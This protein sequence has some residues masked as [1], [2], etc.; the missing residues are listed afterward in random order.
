MD[1][2]VPCWRWLAVVSLLLTYYL[3]D[4]PRVVV[5]QVPPPLTSTSIEPTLQE[6]EL[7]QDDDD[8]EEEEY[9]SAAP[10]TLFQWSY[11]ASYEGGPD[12]DE[13]LVTDR[14]DFTEASSTVGL[15][16]VQLEV[17]YTYTRDD[18][19]TQSVENHSYGEP[20]LRIGMLANWFELRVGWN[21][22][23]EITVAGTQ[24][25]T[26]SGSE[27]LYLGAKIGLTP[28]DGLLPEMALIPQMDVPTATSSGAGGFGSGE[29]L[30]GV[31]W[32]YG[33]EINDCISTA[34]S[35][36]FNRRLDDQT[37]QPF[38]EFA[39]SW[40]IGYSLTEQMGAYTEWFVLVPDGADT[41]R[42]QHFFNGGITYLMSDNIQ[43]D[44]RAGVG[45][46]DAADDYFV[47]S[48]FS[49]RY[50]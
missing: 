36:Q 48:G 42:T 30:P 9:D 39:Q 29:V 33:W 10:G 15:G 43:F 20:L 4:A 7:Q 18:D 11:N 21:Y 13:P 14:P 47:G 25:N 31:N 26:Q 16:V 49:I 32:I 12:L 50:Y 46:N 38:V 23:N 3:F 8:E 22:V 40:T 34:G 44:V 41:N 17:G 35:S 6:F 45:L 28:Q 19:P 24:K 37:Q 2:L 27:D 1:G 5:A